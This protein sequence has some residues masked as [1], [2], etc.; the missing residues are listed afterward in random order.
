MIFIPAYNC[1][2]QLPR[3]IAKIDDRVQACVEEVV[4]IENR[5]TDGTLAAATKAI[6]SLTVKATVMQ[7]NENYSLGGSIKRAFLYAMDNGFDRLIVLHGDDQA[8]VRDLL[9]V[10]EDGD[11]TPSDLVIG[12]RFHPE[13]KLYG[14]STVRKLG[15][16]VLNA[17]FAVVARRRV[18]DLIAGLNIFRV[19]FFSD[20][21]FLNFPN[22]LTFDAHVLLFAFNRK[23]VIKY[24]PVTWREEDQVSNAKTVKQA[25]II[26]RLL[27]RYVFGGGKV[28][29]VNRSG[30]PEGFAYESTIVAQVNG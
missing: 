11:E 17:A 27:V 14:Y 7:N 24:I 2:A 5:S 13:S 20:R 18:Y 1:E 10:L 28:L 29:A 25:L 26:L 6:G 16:R 23:A 30:R 15:N 22:N 4:V 19:G 21:A 8:D 12:A 3:V 9:P